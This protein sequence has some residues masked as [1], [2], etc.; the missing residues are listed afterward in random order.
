MLQYY[1][2]LS[3]FQNVTDSKSI[4]QRG[5]YNNCLQVGGPIGKASDV[6][7]SCRAAKVS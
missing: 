7:R 4:I 5:A 1:W 6:L 2:F 3:K